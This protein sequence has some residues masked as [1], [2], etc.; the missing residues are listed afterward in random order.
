VR[1]RGVRRVVQVS[2]I[3]AEPAAG[4]AYAATKHAADEHLRSTGLEWTILRP[5]LVV[6]RG[7]Y[8][9]TALFRGMAALPSRSRCPETAASRSSRST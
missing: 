2:A 8:G 7:A 9:G 3:S 1:A 5:S 6:A 4:T